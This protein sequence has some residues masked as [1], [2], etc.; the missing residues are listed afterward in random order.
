[1]PGPPKYHALVEAMTETGGDIKEAAKIAGYASHKDAYRVLRRSDVKEMLIKE[2][3]SQL[4]HFTPLAIK[5]LKSLMYSKSE[6]VSLEAVL[7]VLD[8]V[9]INAD[10]PSAHV[11]IGQV[12]INM[13]FGRREIDPAT[14]AIAISTQADMTPP[15][16][17]PGDSDSHPPPLPG[18]SPKPSDHELFQSEM[19]G[20]RDLPPLVR[21]DRF[22]EMFPVE[23]GD[24]SGL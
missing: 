22:Q 12:N 2:A 4:G 9:G 11:Q 17:K 15:P 20:L 8:R 16:Q 13:A 10:T 1:M 19:I 23:P 3:R 24:E 6:K 7:A 14:G 18:N 5:R 21:L